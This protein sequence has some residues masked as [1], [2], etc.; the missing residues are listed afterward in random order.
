L[1]DIV[2]ASTVGPTLRG[3]EDLLDWL[4]RREPL[5]QGEVLG[6]LLD[7]FHR[8]VAVWAPTAP[9]ERPAVP[10]DAAGGVIVVDRTGEGVKPQP[11]D[12]GGWRIWKE[13][14]ADD[15]PILD[16][17]LVDGEDWESLSVFDDVLG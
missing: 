15:L 1:G 6:I 3:P 14:T 16:I 9:G 7:T 2:L 10:L 12:I 4:H 8:P 17:L 5:L 11:E 13:E